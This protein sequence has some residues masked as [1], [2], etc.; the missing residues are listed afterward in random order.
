MVHFTPYIMRSITIISISVTVIENEVY[1]CCIFIY[2]ILT[3]STFR[4]VQRFKQTKKKITSHYTD[5]WMFNIQSS[6]HLDT[7]MQQGEIIT[8]RRKGAEKSAAPMG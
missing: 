6:N 7:G 2:N 8:L 4:A 5:I 1:D 3:A